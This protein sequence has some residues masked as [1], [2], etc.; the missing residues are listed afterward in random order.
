LPHTGHCPGCDTRTDWGEIVRG[1]YARRDGEKENVELTEK[2]RLR[3]MKAA[4]LAEK[5]AERKRKVDEEKQ[6]KRRRTEEAK[7]E[8]RRM[9]ELEKADKPKGK[10]RASSKVTIS[11]ESE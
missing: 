2:A 8:R 11:S 9:K 6:V 3:D 5:L 4:E 7:E 10:R 1:I